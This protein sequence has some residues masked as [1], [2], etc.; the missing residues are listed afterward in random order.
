MSRCIFKYEIKFAYE[1]N[2]Y[3]GSALNAKIRRMYSKEQKN[4][5]EMFFGFIH[6]VLQSE[7]VTYQKV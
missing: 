7:M 2:A 1:P 4:P 5:N 3:S 6:Y